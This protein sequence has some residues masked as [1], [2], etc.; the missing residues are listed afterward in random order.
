MKFTVSHKS[1]SKALQFIS[2]IVN[3]KGVIGSFMFVRCEIVRNKLT[4][5]GQSADVMGSITIDVSGDEGSFCAN[6]FV[7]YD[8][9]KPLSGELEFDIE[10][11]ITIT[12]STGVYSIP[13][14]DEEAWIITNID[15]LGHVMDIDPQILLEGIE[16]AEWSMA[17]DDL[18]PTLQG[19]F[20]D[21]KNK[22]FVST[23]Y[24]TCVTIASVELVSKSDLLIRSAVLSPLKSAIGTETVSVSED[25]NLMKFDLG[26]TIV[27]FRKIHGSYVSYMSVV[28]QESK[29]TVSLSK[30]ELQA[31]IQRLSAFCSIES[32]L[33][34]LSFE[35][36]YLTLEAKDIMFGRSG[37]EK[38]KCDITDNMVISVNSRSLLNILRSRKCETIEI[39]LTAKDR[40][41]VVRGSDEIISV[42]MPF[43]LV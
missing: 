5:S 31:S 37:T 36:G 6:A 3:K 15:S 41:L 21:A 22:K 10:G 39:G 17:T 11:L 42:L 18:R 7:L 4:L 24:S 12:S 35:N 40:P 32:S 9:I 20:V 1:L 38:I 29:M 27:A 8:A 33:M 34:T 2:Q 16:K 28:P 43:L 25:H 26:D 30:N 13:M 23:D 19:I 14:E